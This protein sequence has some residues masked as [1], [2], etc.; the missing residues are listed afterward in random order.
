MWGPHCALLPSIMP[1]LCP[2]SVLASVHTR[3]HCTLVSP[4]S[5]NHVSA[6]FSCIPPLASTPP[7]SMSMLGHESKTLY[8]IKWQLRH[9]RLQYCLLR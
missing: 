6:S 5:T 9:A 7:G 2:P 8:R 4:P 1:P 3:V